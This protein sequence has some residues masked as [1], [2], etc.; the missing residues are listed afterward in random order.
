MSYTC[1]FSLCEQLNVNNSS[2]FSYFLFLVFLL[3]TLSDRRYH[4]TSRKTIH[5]TLWRC[6]L[7]SNNCFLEREISLRTNPARIAVNVKSTL[8]LLLPRMA[9]LCY[10]R[11]EYNY[12]NV[13]SVLERLND[14]L[15]TQ[16]GVLFCYSAFPC[17]IKG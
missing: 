13:K 2:E 7:C 16:L 11:T 12:I 5:C 9:L 17:G 15:R 3:H 1:G 14:K 4:C 8:L 10:V 6:L